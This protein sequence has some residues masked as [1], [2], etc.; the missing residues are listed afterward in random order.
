[1]DAPIK[2]EVFSD[3][4]CPSCRTLY[5]DTTRQ[6]LK[7]Y[8]SKDKVCVIYHEFPLPMHAHA[9]EAARYSQAARRLGLKTWLAV[10]DAIYTHQAE[11]SKTGA[12]G[13]VVSKALTP[14]EFQKVTK[15]LQDPSIN[16]EIDRTVAEGQ[17]R[18]VKS[19]P[20]LFVSAIGKEQPFAGVIPYP[21]LKEF[22]DRIV[23]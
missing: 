17:K 20:T 8:C 13:P 7:E 9:R 1:M 2:I 19:T 15:L 10:I 5:L 4:E 12:V 14:E 23:K 3:F 16:A 18:G 22:F 21:V 6:V 11:W